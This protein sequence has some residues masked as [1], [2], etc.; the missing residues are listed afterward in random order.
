MNLYVIFPSVKQYIIKF[1]IIFIF[2]EK[3]INFLKKNKINKT[4]DQEQ[5]LEE[6]GLTRTGS[7]EFSDNR[8]SGALCSRVFQIYLVF[9]LKRFFF[10][11]AASICTIIRQRIKIRLLIID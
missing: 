5:S 1:F 11:L 6:T 3:F 4:A 10:L 9:I 2:F 8:A 7:A